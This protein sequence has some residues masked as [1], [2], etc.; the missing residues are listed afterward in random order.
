MSFSNSAFEWSF[1]FERFD[2]E[3][4][5][6][7]KFLILVNDELDLESLSAIKNLACVSNG[8]VK[9][10]AVTSSSF[11]NKTY[12]NYF[13]NKIGDLEKHSR[14][15][16]LL[17]SNIRIESAILNVKLRSKFLARNTSILSLGLNFNSSLPSE[18]INLNFSKVIDFF[19][20][21]SPILS[22][23]FLVS[24][25]PLLFLG[26]NLKNRF[27]GTNTFIAYLKKFAPSSIIFVL[28]ESCNSS[29]LRLI[30]IKS[31]CNRD[32]TSSE[33]LVSINLKDTVFVRSFL[34]LD[35]M[36][37][38]FSFSPHVLDATSNFDLIVPIKSEYEIEG[39]FI[40]LEG[41][42]QRTMRLESKTNFVRSAQN[43]FAAI[44]NSAAVF[45]KFLNY[46]EELS[47]C[48]KS[49]S[50]VENKFMNWNKNSLQIF[51]IAK[52]S[53]YPA[54]S[55]T[56]DFYTKNAFCNRSLTMLERSQET[57]AS[58]TNFS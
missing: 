25:N 32:F 16:F 49:F 37:E 11:K 10:K 42:P 55:L 12:D 35:E 38:S 41:R 3:K 2:I 5:S 45:P 26:S 48:F 43:I 6:K 53:L 54:K 29:G 46:V 56:E 20:G 52:A 57:R 51:L 58:S 47:E 23:L 36:T 8:A 7:A 21:K 22:K 15:C 13:K 28:E 30:N 50:F 44:K 24:K 40:N 31:L 27:S 33:V 9:I 39:T 17:S 4:K 34:N 18:F 1:F 14:F 19:E